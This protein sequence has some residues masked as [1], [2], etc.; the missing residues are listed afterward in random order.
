MRKVLFPVLLSIFLYQ[1]GLAQVQTQNLHSDHT[2]FGL[3]KLPPRADFFAFEDVAVLELSSSQQTKETS[4]RFLSLNGNWKFN[5]V[6]S[7]KDRPKNYYEV[8]LDD[9]KWDIIPVPANWAHEQEIGIQ[10]RQ[11]FLIDHECI[12]DDR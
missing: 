5:W 1:S 8:E 9:S 4:K 2:I 11:L 3:N 12:T 7:P 10:D 6:R